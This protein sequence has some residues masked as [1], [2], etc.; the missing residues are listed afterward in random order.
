MVVLNH[1]D[2]NMSNLG[3]VNNYT[4]HSQQKKPVWFWVVTVVSFQLLFG[5]ITVLANLAQIADSL[6]AFCKEDDISMIQGVCNTLKKKQRDPAN[7]PV[8]LSPI[9][10]T[11]VET[12]SS[13]NTAIDKQVKPNHTKQSSVSENQIRFKRAN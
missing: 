2:C 6:Q 4:N 12:R 7:D 10:F 1:Q 11:K 9:R 8:P 13:V 3:R 5:S